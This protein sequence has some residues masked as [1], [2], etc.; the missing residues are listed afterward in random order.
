MNYFKINYDK[1]KN[2]KQIKYFYIVALL[3]I[4]LIVL[5][6]IAS[7]IKVHHKLTFYGIYNDK[8]IVFKVNNKLSDIIKN[9]NLISFNNENTTY[10]VLEFG[11]YEINNE[12]IYQD[13]TITVDKEF[14]DNEI[15]LITI[16]YNKETILKYILDLF[17]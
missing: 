4:T 10:K 1:L 17:K 11:D 5:I 6:I 9:N 12:E 14:I 15:G 3:F 16:Y 2:L 13:I 7:N 8:K